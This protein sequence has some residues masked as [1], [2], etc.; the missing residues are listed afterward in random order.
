MRY[1]A[2]T[3]SAL[4]V[5][6]EDRLQEVLVRVVVVLADVVLDGL[7]GVPSG[8]VRNLA[9]N[10]VGDVGLA[11]SVQDVLAD[12]SKEF[13]VESA[14]GTLGESPLL[15]RVVGCE[16]QGIKNVNPVTRYDV[17]SQLRAS[18]SRNKGSVCWAKVMATNQWL[19]CK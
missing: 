4:P 7:C 1:D 8:V 12:G 19:T 16:R 9:G 3:H 18:H 2:T 11:D 13:T 10:V 17:E 6:V 14:E 5:V 15:G